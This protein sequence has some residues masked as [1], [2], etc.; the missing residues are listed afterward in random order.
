MTLRRGPAG[1]PDLAFAGGWAALAIAFVSPLCALS[2]AL[3]AARIAHHLLLVAVAAPLLALAWRDRIEA[4]LGAPLPIVPL[5]VLHV[6]LFWSGT[7][8]HPMRRHGA[9]RH[10]W[11][12]E[13]SL[14][15]SAL[16]SV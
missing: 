4:R 14:L 2:A 13:A 7:H 6:V 1:R 5:A 11:A 3:F 8:R 15:G 10:Y 16:L 9:A 12:M